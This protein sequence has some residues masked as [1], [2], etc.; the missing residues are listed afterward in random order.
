MLFRSRRLYAFGECRGDFA[1]FAR[2]PYQ[3]LY[4]DMIAWA[5]HELVSGHDA[6]TVTVPED[7]TIRRSALEFAGFGN[8]GHCETTAW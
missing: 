3:F 4:D 1:I 8:Q 7:D 6:L 5:E 2:E